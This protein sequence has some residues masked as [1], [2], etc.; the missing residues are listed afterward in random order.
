[1]HVAEDEGPAVT[2][3]KGHRQTHGMRRAI[4]VG[5]DGVQR[6]RVLESP[7]RLLLQ[8]Q[9]RHLL[10][11]QRFPQHLIHAGPAESTFSQPHPSSRR[12][13]LPCDV[14]PD[15]PT[16]ASTKHIMALATRRT[17]TIRAGVAARTQVGARSGMGR[18]MAVS[19][20]VVVPRAGVR[21]LG[22]RIG[23]DRGGS[24]IHRRK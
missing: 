12:R 17:S 7:L 15:G 22:V 18:V 1:M 14:A 8:A 23:R 3:R 4:Q 6:V 19:G 10:Q 11:T 2:Q 5:A 16:R 24:G 9:L 13:H 20:G 21:S